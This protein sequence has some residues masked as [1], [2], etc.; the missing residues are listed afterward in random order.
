MLE[1]LTAAPAADKLFQR[2]NDARPRGWLE[3]A[4]ETWFSRLSAGRH[5]FPD[6]VNQASAAYRFLNYSLDPQFT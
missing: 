6:S 4:T 3:R 2:S 1:I 5:N